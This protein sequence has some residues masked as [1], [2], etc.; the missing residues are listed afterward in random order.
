MNSLLRGEARK[1]LS[2][3]SLLVLAGVTVIYPALALLPAVTAP[4]APQV[5]AGSILQLLRGGADVLTLAALLIGVLA[6]TGEYRHGT[7]VPNLL[8][9]PWRERWVSAKVGFQAAF[10]ALLGLA[11]ST[12]G[13]L[14]G[15]LY[16]SGRGVAVDVLSRQ[17]LLTV[18]AVTLVATLYASAGAAVGAL[19]KNQTAAVAGVLIW[20]FAVENAIPLVLRTPGLKRWLPGGAAD[21]LLHAA[22]PVAGMAN[23]WLALALLAGLAAVLAGAAVVATKAADVH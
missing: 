8:V 15:G 16:L 18:A 20:V 22:D 2:T 11:V 9:A 14:A 4:E 21:R 10:A 1:L 5:D 7:I 3:R 17:V 12:V 13:L 19:V 23:P 6:V